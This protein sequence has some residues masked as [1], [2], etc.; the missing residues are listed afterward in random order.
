MHDYINLCVLFKYDLENMIPFVT[1]TFTPNNDKILFNQARYDINDVNNILSVD[2]I[3]HFNKI[4]DFLISCN[5]PLAKYRSIHIIG[6]TV[7]KNMH[8]VQFDNTLFTKQNNTDKYYNCMYINYKPAIF[9]NKSNPQTTIPTVNK[10]KSSK[11][12]QRRIN[13]FSIIFNILTIVNCFTY[14]TLSAAHENPN[15]STDIVEHP[16]KTSF[17]IIFKGCL[18]TLLGQ[19]VSNFAPYYSNFIFNALMA[20]VNFQLSKTNCKTPG[21]LFCMIDS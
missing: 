7:E 15:F 6:S 12:Q 19:Y 8:F 3:E 16:F 9:D 14:V 13:V 1:T 10:N 5:Y 21:N 20:Y 11:M 4:I 2:Q 17:H 18:Y